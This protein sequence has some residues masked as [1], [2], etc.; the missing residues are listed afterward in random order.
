MIRAY[1]LYLRRPCCHP[2]CRGL[3]TRQP[4]AP[5]VPTRA[6][7]R[8]PVHFDIAN[9]LPMPL[10]AFVESK[11]LPWCSDLCKHLNWPAIGILD[12][13]GGDGGGLL[14][15]ALYRYLT[16][17]EWLDYRWDMNCLHGGRVVTRGV[18]ACQFDSHRRLWWRR[19]VVAAAF[20]FPR[21]VKLIT[22]FIEFYNIYITIG[23]ERTCWRCL[24]SRYV[25][26][27]SIV[28][29]LMTHLFYI[30]V[31][32]ISFYHHVLQEL[33]HYCYKFYLHFIMYIVPCYCIACWLLCT[34]SEMTNKRCTINQ[35]CGALMFPSICAWINGCANSLEADDLRRHYAHYDISL[36]DCQYFII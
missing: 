36:M 24:D 1:E 17:S 35:W 31:N 28:L 29:V 30:I 11:W 2:R 13:N 10:C 34:L 26:I 3:A 20:I 32:C 8:R 14:I 4:S 7:W 21:H 25:K 18:G 5:L 9:L 27:R 16:S 12:D 6:Q 23:T 15:P 22:D 33:V 19:A